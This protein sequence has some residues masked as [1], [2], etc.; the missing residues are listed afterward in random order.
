MAA[1]AANVVAI[2]EP[3]QY[4]SKKRKAD[5]QSPHFFS[6]CRLMVNVSLLEIWRSV[7]ICTIFRVQGKGGD[8]NCNG[9]VCC[10]FW[11]CIA[12]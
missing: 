8:D 1:T 12:V 4:E 11:P 9:Q 10:A 7:A 3:Q 2:P 5:R 6:G